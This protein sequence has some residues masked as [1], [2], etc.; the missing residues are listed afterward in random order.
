MTA[1]VTG[2]VLVLVVMVLV[3]VLFVVQVLM[4][5]LCLFLVL[6]LILVLVRQKRREQCDACTVW[7]DCRATQQVGCTS[8]CFAV[9]NP[10]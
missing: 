4:L 2:V 7:L 1:A 3:L 8:V 6:V 9:I 5:V 10:L